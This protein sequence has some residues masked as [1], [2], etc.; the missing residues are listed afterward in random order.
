MYFF[1]DK[2]PSYSWA[3]PVMSKWTSVTVRP[4]PAKT[5]RTFDTN[6]IDQKEEERKIPRYSYW[7]R[8]CLLLQ[9][10]HTQKQN[11]KTKTIIVIMIFLIS[12][13]STP[14]RTR[15]V[16]DKWLS[17]VVPLLIDSPYNIGPGQNTKTSI[18]IIK[19]QAPFEV[20]ANSDKVSVILNLW[21]E[22]TYTYNLSQ[23][24]PSRT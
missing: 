21:E 7:G 1:S 22:D 18:I 10:H 14:L 20:A 12:T 6:R 15:L 3:P 8:L 19:G 13:Y 4:T 16:V 2:E 24:L 23:K 9:L 5:D 11:G 17:K